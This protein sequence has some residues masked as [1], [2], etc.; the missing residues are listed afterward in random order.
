MSMEMSFQSINLEVL[1]LKGRNN[2]LLQQRF[3]TIKLGTISLFRS[4]AKTDAF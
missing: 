2:L 1:P 3:D 4:G